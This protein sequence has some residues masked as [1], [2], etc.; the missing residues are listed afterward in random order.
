LLL[1]QHLIYTVP[2][3][4]GVVCTV[5]AYWWPTPPLP[6]APSA[7]KEDSSFLAGLGRVLT[8]PSFLLL[9]VVWG[10][11]SGIFNALVTLLPQMVCPFGYSDVSNG[12]RC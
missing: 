5:I 9:L 10:C 11:A 4:V 3:V 12:G 6:P 7:H 2:A 1:P 8:T